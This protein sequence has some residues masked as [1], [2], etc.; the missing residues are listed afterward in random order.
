MELEDTEIRCMITTRGCLRQVLAFYYVLIPEGGENYSLFLHPVSFPV[1]CFPLDVKRNSYKEWHIFIFL[2]Y[3]HH[4]GALMFPLKNTLYMLST[5]ISDKCTCLW[6]RISVLWVG[7]NILNMCFDSYSSSS[8]CLFSG[9]G[10]S[11]RGTC[12]QMDVLLFRLGYSDSS[13][14]SEFSYAAGCHESK[15]YFLFIK[16]F[17][18]PQGIILFTFFLF[19]CPFHSSSFWEFI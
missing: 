8:C 1:K 3:V 10:S 19:F 14:S 17:L 15:N 2:R 9:E 11:S 18:F 7:F 13:Y 6:I 4:L 16:S 12:F 5:L